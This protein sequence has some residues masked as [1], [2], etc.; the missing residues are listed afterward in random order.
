MVMAIGQ[1]VVFAKNGQYLA[2][3]KLMK[4]LHR[5]CDWAPIGFLLNIH[6]GRDGEGGQE[7]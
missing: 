2:D 4:F 6:P 5:G 3:Y 1:Q 7:E